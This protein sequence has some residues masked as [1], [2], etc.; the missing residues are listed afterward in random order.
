MHM[1]FENRLEGYQIILYL[2]SVDID[3]I[4]YQIGKKVCGWDNL[5]LSTRLRRKK[6]HENQAL[7]LFAR[8]EKDFTFQIHLIIISRDFRGTT[9]RNICVLLLTEENLS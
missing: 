7:M 2:I 3:R 9:G 1:T 8:K 5:K 4:F 6:R